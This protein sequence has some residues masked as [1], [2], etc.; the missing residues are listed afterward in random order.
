MPRI[1]MKKARLIRYRCSLDNRIHG[2]VNHLGA[3][4]RRTV[5][6]RSSRDAI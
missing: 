3:V 1:I 2:D 6:S 5:R 4:L